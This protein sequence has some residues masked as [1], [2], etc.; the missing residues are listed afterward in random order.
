[1]IVSREV[2]DDVQPPF[3]EHWDGQR[4]GSFRGTLDAFTETKCLR[5]RLIHTSNLVRRILRPSRPLHW[6]SGTYGQ[7]RQTLKYL[8]SE[9]FLKEIRLSR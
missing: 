5:L 3:P 2:L 6:T 7:L 9:R 4:L 1:M 8:V